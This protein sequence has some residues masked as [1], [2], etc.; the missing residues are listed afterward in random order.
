MKGKREIE[1]IPKRKKFKWY[2]NQDYQKTLQR[3][4]PNQEER[5]NKR[6]KAQNATMSTINT[7]QQNA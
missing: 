6:Q 3:R 7:K 1:K 5:S 2:P 4:D